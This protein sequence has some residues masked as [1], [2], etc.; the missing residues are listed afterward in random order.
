MEDEAERSESMGNATT[1]TTNEKLDSS[2]T[3][4]EEVKIKVARSINGEIASVIGKK[5]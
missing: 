5:K 3:I 2:V 4:K 1:K